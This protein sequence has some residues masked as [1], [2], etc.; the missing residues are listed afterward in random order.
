MECSLCIDR[1][2]NLT[3]ISGHR[4]EVNQGETKLLNEYFSLPAHSIFSFKARILKK[5]Y[6]TTYNPSCSTPLR[7]QTVE[8][9]IHELGTAAPYYGCNDK[10]DSFENLTS[11]DCCSVNMMRFFD[12]SQRPA[13]SHGHRPSL[14]DEVTFEFLPYIQRPLDLHHICTKLYASP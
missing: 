13:G 10:I 6:H 4:F 8:Y 3:Q 5:H 1:K 14:R 11:P 2:D 7:R 12:S 9:W